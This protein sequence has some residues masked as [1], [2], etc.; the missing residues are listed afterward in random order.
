V[1]CYRLSGSRYPSNSGDG[2]AIAGGRWNP[3]GV[4]VVYAS[5]TPSLAVLE[6]LVH[7]A[8]LPRKHVLTPI[9]VPSDVRIESVRAADLPKGWNSPIPR[10]ATQDLGRK[11]AAELRSAILAAPSSIISTEV[12]YVINPFHHDFSRIKFLRST[13]FRFD[14]RL[15]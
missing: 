7:F 14:P 9:E 1:I 11:W 8:V 6:V 2:A 10:R 12:N 15:R 13:P 3:I 5:A 4:P